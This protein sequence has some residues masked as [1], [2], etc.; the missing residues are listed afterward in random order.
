MKNY[1][2]AYDDVFRTQTRDCPELVIPFINEVFQE[3]YTKEE[4]R[5]RDNIHI[6]GKTDGTK[7]RR[8]TDSYFEIRDKIYHLECQSWRDKRIII[9]IFEYDTEIA[10][11]NL[12]V[13]ENTLKVAFPRTALLSLRSTRN[14]PSKMKIVIQT[15][16]GET[17]YLVPVIKI[18]DYTLEELFEKNLLFLLPFYLF[19]YEKSF[20]KNVPNE[21]REKLLCDIREDYAYIR[22]KLEELRE[23]GQLSAYTEN[24]LIDMT[25]LVADS[26]SRNHEDVRKEVAGTMGGKVLEYRTKTVYNKGLAEGRKEVMQEMAL[27]LLKRRGW[28]NEQI[29]SL[30]EKESRLEEL[31]RWNELLL[32]AESLEELERAISQ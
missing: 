28:A 1:G 20:K 8:E 16:D 17:S 10:L 32:D 12:K 14:E 24:T 15:P 6:M 13:S 22:Q 4:I 2:T 18:T 27:K 30:V 26:L 19:Q 7:E 21:E 9:R 23:S 29:V 25:N 5:Y 3:H 31:E 11:D